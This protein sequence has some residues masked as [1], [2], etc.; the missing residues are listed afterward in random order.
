MDEFVLKAE[1][2]THLW[3]ASSTKVSITGIAEGSSMVAER[4]NTLVHA[5]LHFEQITM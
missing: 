3:S 4:C 2:Q 1:N 5:V